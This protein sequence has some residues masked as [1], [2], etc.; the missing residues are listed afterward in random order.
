M[1][2]GS[3]AQKSTIYR[4]LELGKD[5]AT[6]IAGVYTPE[7]EVLLPYNGREVLYVVGEAMLSA[8][9][10]GVGNWV[11]V[12]VPGYVVKWHSSSEG[13]VFISEVEPIG[14]PGSREE[15]RKII[16]QREST[17]RIQFE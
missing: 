9:C 3:T 6:G 2:A 11:Y 8:S 14:D 7:K 5:V 10:C 12:A 13:S 16:E 4:H 17:D 1:P 15:L